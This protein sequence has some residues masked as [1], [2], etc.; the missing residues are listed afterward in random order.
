MSC[1]YERFADHAV[2]LGRLMK[3]VVPGSGQA[4]GAAA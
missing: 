4:T 3:S 2:V 1:L